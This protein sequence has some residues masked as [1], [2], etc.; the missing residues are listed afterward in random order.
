MT[1]SLH[2]MTRPLETRLSINL[3]RAAKT[4]NAFLVLAVFAAAALGQFVSFYFH[5]LTVALLLLNAINFYWRHI[6]KTHALLANFGFLAQIR[7]IVESLGPEFR[8]YL[9]SN[10]DEER[11]FSR[12]DRTEVYRKAK[13]IDSSSAFGTQRDFDVSEMTL[14]HS[15]FPVGQEELLPYRLEFGEEV[16]EQTLLQTRPKSVRTIRQS[17]N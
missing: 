7:Y 4:A 9:Y 10:D 17:S 6:Q 2:K 15:F 14:R 11:P 5:F 1:S 8:Q 12:N 13:G 3:D 16:G